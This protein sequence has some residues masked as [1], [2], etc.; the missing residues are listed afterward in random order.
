M[1]ALLDRAVAIRG[2]CRR[3]A[4]GQHVEVFI[5]EDS[6][7]RIYAFL[8]GTEAARDTARDYDRIARLSFLST[9]PQIYTALSQA[10]D[11]RQEERS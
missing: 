3:C 8:E 2:V 1:S 4:P 11:A 10:I 7:P 6:P 5:T 9:V